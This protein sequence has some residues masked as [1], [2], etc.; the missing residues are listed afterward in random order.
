MLTGSRNFENENIIMKYWIL[1]IRYFYET[2]M[3]TLQVIELLII[4]YIDKLKT[5]FILCKRQRLYLN[6]DADADAK[7]SMSRFPNGPS[8]VI[9]K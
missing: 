5:W 2:L 9:K 4:K 1:V 6:V 8:E 7:I 3:D